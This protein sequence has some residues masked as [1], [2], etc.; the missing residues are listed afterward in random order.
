M[1]GRL[2]RAEVTVVVYL[3]AAEDDAYDAAEH[4]ASLEILNGCDVDIGSTMRE[5]LDAG[6]AA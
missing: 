2:Y 4:A 3:Y 6:V 5:L 1:T